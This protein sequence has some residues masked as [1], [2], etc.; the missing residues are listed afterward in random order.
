MNFLRSELLIAVLKQMK[1][2]VKQLFIRIEFG[3]NSEERA[4]SKAWSPR[5]EA[6]FITAPAKT[7]EFSLENSMW[8]SWSRARRTGCRAEGRFWANSQ[9]WA[10]KKWPRP[11]GR[12]AGGP[13]GGQENGKFPFFGGVG[14][15]T[16]PRPRAIGLAPGPREKNWSL[17][18]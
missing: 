14:G 13:T 12:G 5:R 4:I 10:S 3:L 18:C 11:G 2:F 9:K 6:I 7:T 17:F 16:G 15:G 8:T 1:L